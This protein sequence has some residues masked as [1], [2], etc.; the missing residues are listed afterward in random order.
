MELH[1]FEKE[2]RIH[3][4]ETGPDGRLNI[5]SLFNYMQDIAS[6]HAIRL[7]FGRDDLLRHNHF[8]VLSRMY[9]EINE[10]PSWEEKII[11][12]T[13]PNGTD[14]LFAMRNY[15]AE[16][17]D[18]RHIASG[19]SSWLIVDRTS[20][21]IQR[22]GELLTQ[23]SVGFQPEKSPVRSAEKLAE[24]GEDKVPS[25][26]FRV[27]IS[28]L[29]INLHTNNANYLKWAY[30][31]YDLNFVIN[32]LPCSIEINYL[33][34]SKFGDEIVIFSREGAINVNEHSVFRTSDNKELCRIRIGWKE[35]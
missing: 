2:Y 19:T 23:F 7:G 13:W 17:P 21:R 32:H 22:P 11:M 14:K 3:V 33:A 35:L 28:D 29:D 9:V 26:K 1:Q 8:W 20:K 10:W 27:K 4:Y 18:G 12:K 15:K 30:N 25:S 5:F 6:E 31:T 16:Y 34:E 24:C